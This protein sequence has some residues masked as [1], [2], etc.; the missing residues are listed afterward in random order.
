[1]RFAMFFI[2][3]ASMLAETPLPP[4]PPPVCST[5]QHPGEDA[6][7]VCRTTQA[8][9]SLAH[10]LVRAQVP[11]ASSVL[12]SAV[13]ATDDAAKVAIDK[14]IFGHPSQSLAP[15]MAL[16]IDSEVFFVRSAAPL[17]LVRG[18]LFTIPANH[19]AGTK[20]VLLRWGSISAHDADAMTRGAGQAMTDDAVRGLT[21]IEKAHY[22]ALGKS[23]SEGHVFARVKVT[24]Q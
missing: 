5:V 16:L 4:A 6:F 12:M 17:A 23:P 7:E 1:M 10:F 22:Y 8:E 14:I 21:A 2:L 19:A 9:A 20:V 15:G 18:A 13:S 11:N 24:S 3:V